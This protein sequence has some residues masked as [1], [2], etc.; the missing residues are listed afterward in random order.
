M[1]MKKLKFRK[2]ICTALALIMASV[3]AGCQNGSPANTENSDPTGNTDKLSDS[4]SISSSDSTPEAG[5]LQEIDVVLDWYPNAIHAF[6]YVAIEK[7]YYE[8][9]GLKVNIQFP[10]NETDALSL[11][12]A[13]EADI[14]A[15]YQPAIITT[16]TNQ[17]VPV[18]SIG[19][20]CQKPLNIILSL[21]EE[22][23]TTPQDLEGKT[24]G[25]A[26][27]DLSIA[28]VKFLMENSGVTYDESKLVNVGFDLMSS[29]TTKNVDA[30]IGC[31]VNH[32]V[33]QMIE[34]GFDV[35]YFRLDDYGVPSYYELVF[36]ANDD[37]IANDP[38][39]LSGFLRASQKGF[40]DM[41]ANPDEAL[42][43]LL[44]HQNTENFP[45]SETVEKQSM[46]TL[47]PLMEM[48][49]APFLSQDPDIWQENID[50][51]YEQGLTDQKLQVQDV[52]ADIQY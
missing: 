35:N 47:I 30:T 21:A 9:E 7:G 15:Y 51:L 13:G 40:N 33:P 2:L 29:M 44:K 24:I 6:M 43:I 37:T 38:Q 20:V 10:A 14:G 19:A 16:R 48:D 50:W 25:Y 41:K 3:M 45:L 46:E 26:G 42:S 5:E 4:A 36:L 31:L 8:Q 52:M 17:K 22:N 12:A 11:V 32:E 18:K 34:E 39:M 1:K 27:T 23:I 49:N 28:L